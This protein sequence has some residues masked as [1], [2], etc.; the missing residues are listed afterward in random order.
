MQIQ[1]TS[2]KA[3]SL[4]EWKLNFRKSHEDDDRDLSDNRYKPR[5][6]HHSQSGTTRSK[7]R[8]MEQILPESHQKA[9]TLPAPWFWSFGF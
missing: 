2:S 3:E 5:D 4:E 9:P 1:K 6:A 7:K 8:D